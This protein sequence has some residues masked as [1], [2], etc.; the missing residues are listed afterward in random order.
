MKL[1]SDALRLGCFLL[2]APFKAVHWASFKVASDVID[3]H[4][5][6][7][8]AKGSKYALLIL[9]QPIEFT[10]SSAVMIWNRASIRATV[11]GGTNIWF[12]FSE[13]I[14]NEIGLSNPIPDLVTGDF[15]SAETRCL[16]YYQEHGAKVIHTP[17]QDETDFN[18]CIRELSTELVAREL[19]VNAVIAVCE[20]TGRL[21]H[22]LSNLN[23]LQKARDIL[24][25]V[26]LYLLTHS[27][28]SWVLHTGRHRI[29]VDDRVI[30]QHC[31]L[32]PLGQPAYVTSSGL[33][34]D[35]DCLKL[36]FGGLISTS[37]KFT[38]QATVTL[39]TDRPILFTMTL[40][41]W[42]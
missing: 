14:E 13:G 41:P 31:G 2:S 29:H 4:P 37:N 19:K 15:D 18:K 23:T 38:D 40:P 7:L 5:L 28:I 39:E 25:S 3:W 24:G 12:K 21:D 10:K 9:N 34:W 42:K 22:I 6:E 20:N 8:L 17:D 30:D 11:D 32:I 33:K 27:S 35:M 1:V 26:P 16:K 36:E